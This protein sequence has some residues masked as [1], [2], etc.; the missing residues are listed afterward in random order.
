MG[1]YQDIQ[2]DVTEAMAG[3]LADA[4]AILVITES[5][6]S[7]AYNPVGGTVTSTPV[8]YTMECIVMGDDEEKKDEEDYSTDYVKLLILDSKRTIPEFKVGM[9][10]TVRQAD[11]T[12][13][14]ITID[15]VGATYVLK[16]RKT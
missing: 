16:C 5:V 8:Q 10:A 14:K 13:G 9:K 12:I 15:P 6:S 7:T 11:Y 1:L 2:D 3:D 4:V